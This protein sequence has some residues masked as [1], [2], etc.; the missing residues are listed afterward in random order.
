[1]FTLSNF[2]LK[3]STT[4]NMSL[5]RC[6]DHLDVVI[7]NAGIAY[8]WELLEK[9][10]PEVVREHL[11]VNTLGSII[12]FQ[13]VLPLLRKA[14][15]SKFIPITTDLAAITN[16]CE[17]PVSAVALSKIGVNFIT[18]RIHLENSKDASRKIDL[19]SIIDFRFYQAIS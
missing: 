7:A 6:T 2:D 4:L 19:A 10:D 9:V 17:Y 8:N 16:P 5:P 11:T 14:K 18:T 1:M 12:L 3:S 13:A 15:R